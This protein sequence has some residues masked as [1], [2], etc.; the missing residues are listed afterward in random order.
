MF[1]RHTTIRSFRRLVDGLSKIAREN[2]DFEETGLDF[3]VFG[4]IVVAFVCLMLMAS[5]ARSALN[6]DRSLSEAPAVSQAR[7]AKQYIDRARDEWNASDFQAVVGTLS[8][9]IA[10]PSLS[11]PVRATVHFDR[12]NAYLQL[13]EVANALA[14]LDTSLRFAHPEP[15]R[16]Y[17][18]RG[19]AYE[20]RGDRERA[21][22]NYIRALNAAPTNETINLHVMRFFRGE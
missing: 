22:W 2:E 1:T 11:D 4:V 20:I 16:V 19:V 12:G 14:D 18:L 9:L 13:G 8:E 21:A 3:R 5:T 15:E 10:I 6:E 17:L 7:T